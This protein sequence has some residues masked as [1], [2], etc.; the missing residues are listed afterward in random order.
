VSNHAVLSIY[1]VEFGNLASFTPE[2]EAQVLSHLRKR[3]GPQASL[4]FSETSLGGRPGRRI[5]ASGLRA[6]APWG[7]L[8]AWQVRGGQAV[9]LELL[10]PLPLQGEM[11][12]LFS[13]LCE[14]LTWIVPERG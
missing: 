12:T 14:D 4:E 5:R 8:A 7:L 3:L 11:E 9:V 1:R 10:Y 2:M 6:K 13:T